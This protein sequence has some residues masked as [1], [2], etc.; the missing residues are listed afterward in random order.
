MLWVAVFCVLAGLAI[1][2][3]QAPSND[4]D[5][6]PDVSRTPW[7][8]I[9]GDRVTL[10][11]VRNC[12]YRTET[13]YTC[14]WETR[15]YDL[16]SLKGIDLF[17]TWWGSP[18]IAHPILSFDFGNGQYVAFSIETRKEVGEEYSAVKGFFRNYELIY[19]AA[20]ERD[21]IR[22]RTNYR[23]GEETY[24][25]RTNASPQ[26]ARAMF[27]DYLRHA[28]RL[29]DQPEWYNALTSNC[30]TNIRVHAAA[31]GQLMPWDWRILLSGRFDEMLYERG[32]LAGSL[33]FSELKRR[34][35]INPA[36]R[37]AGGST[38]FSVLIRKDRPAF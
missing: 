11:N 26:N 2:F 19:I 13:D 37:A 16:S 1:Y 15:V 17:M 6:Q 10:H 3:S 23:S 18:W 20:D 25:F 35:H 7:A 31:R 38:D 5:W 9:D 12:D 24:L 33:P 29:H 32:A 36:A 4:R 30:T 21:V 22:L 28:N 34:A 27:V 8:Q 14:R